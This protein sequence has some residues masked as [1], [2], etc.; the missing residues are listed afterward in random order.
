M[1][2]QDAFDRILM[3]LHQATFED[4]HWS[5]A[6]ALIDEACGIKG[7]YLIHSAGNSEDDIRI[8]L[9]RFLFRGQRKEEWE[10][11][12]F[13][14]YYPV[15]ERV[16]RVRTLP[17]SQLVHVTDLYTDEEK[18]TSLFYN[19]ALPL[20]HVQNSLNVRLDGPNDSRI[21]WVL[22]DPVDGD[23]WTFARTE[24]VRRLLPHFRLYMIVR[25]ALVEAGALGSSLTRLLQKCGS[26]IIYLNRHGR[27][28]A[29]TDRARNLL[30]KGDCLFDQDG[31]LHARSPHDNAGL[32]QLLARAL[33]SFGERGAQTMMDTAAEC[34]VGAL[35]SRDVKLVGILEHVW[36]SIGRP[37]QNDY[38][39]TLPHRENRS[40]RS[41]RARAGSPP[42]RASR[43]AAI[44]RPPTG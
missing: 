40:P 12:Y 31:F 19:E 16:P 30:L 26:G 38:V 42:A 20:G 29:A 2:E 5:A 34:E 6:S 25:Q 44:P 4:A 10:R 28:A 1:S 35:A 27:V 37:E 36:V 23:E 9:T 8:F 7:N 33:P 17:D 41:P 22:A 11:R 14:V 39:V 15:D 43:N 3:A 13:D 32:Q 24:M 18:T 21:V